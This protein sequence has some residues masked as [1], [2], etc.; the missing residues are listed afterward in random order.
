[1][2]YLKLASLAIF[3]FAASNSFSQNYDIARAYYIKAKEAFASE[4]YQEVIENLQEAKKELGST[5][6][7][8]IYLEL[9]SKYNMNKMDPKVGELALEFIN[10]TDRQDDRIQEVSLIAVDN[11]KLIDEEIKGE[12]DLYNKAIS[13]RRLSDLRN[14]LELYPDNEE[15]LKNI[16]ELIIQKDNEQFA[17]AKANNTVEDLEQYKQDFP[18]GLHMAE[19]EELL[20]M[21]RQ[22]ELFAKAQNNNDIDLYKSYL[23]QFPNGKYQT[24]VSTA[25]NTAM[26]SKANAEFDNKNYDYAE[27]SYKNY[28]EQFPSGDQASYAKSQLNKIQRIEEK[29]ARVSK[30][31]SKGY[32]MLTYS[33]AEEYGIE[34]GKLHLDKVST[35]FGLSANESV[36]NLTFAP[37]AEVETFPADYNEATLSANFGLTYKVYYPIW[38]YA[39]GGVKYTEYFIEEESENFS[40]EVV[41]QSPYQFFPEAGVQIKITKFLVIKAGAQFNEDEV[42]Y[43][44]GLG[45]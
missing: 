14:Y 34:F 40:F 31:T 20:K 41:D 23:I 28:I 12:K 45:F 33:T 36:A 24:E 17:Q 43:K 4:Q 27:V 29:M 2:K 19:L 26:I 30:R 37:E 15:K 25:L 39:G 8:I 1:M 6:P 44:I 16:R 10:S 9:M 3:L 13:S 22:E 18:K 35:Y 38:V 21:A 32:F 5:N 11:K 7:D 42:V